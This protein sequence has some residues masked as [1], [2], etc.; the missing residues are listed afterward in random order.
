MKLTLARADAYSVNVTLKPF[1]LSLWAWRGLLDRLVR[2]PRFFKIHAAAICGLVLLGLLP[3]SAFAQSGGVDLKVGSLAVK[4]RYQG[5]PFATNWILGGPFVLQLTQTNNPIFTAT[6]TNDVVFT[7]ILQGTYQAHINYGLKGDV[8]PPINVTIDPAQTQNLTTEL[9]GVLA[10]VTLKLVENGGLLASSHN[11]ELR[12][13]YPLLFVQSL[14][15]GRDTMTA[16]VIAGAGTIQVPDTTPARVFNYQVA[17]GQTKDL[18]TLDLGTGIVELNLLFRGASLTGFNLPADQVFSGK[19]TPVGGGGTVFLGF[20]RGRRTLLNALP[21]D[22]H[23][24]VDFLNSSGTIAPDFAG[25]IPVTVVAGPDPVRVDFEVGGVFGMASGV[26]TENGSGLLDPVR[27][28]IGANGSAISVSD[29]PAADE[30]GPTHVDAL[31][32]PGNV[33]LQLNRNLTTLLVTNLP[34]IQ[35]S[36]KDWGSV[37]LHTGDLLVKPTYNGKALGSTGVTWPYAAGLF[38]NSNLVFQAELGTNGFSFESAPVG[39]YQLQFFNTFV[40]SVQPVGSAIPVAIAQG[41]TNSTV[42][43][44]ASG[45][46]LVSGRLTEN[47]APPSKLHVVTFL[48][49]GG[50]VLRTNMTP[51]QADFRIFLPTGSDALAVEKVQLPFDI[52]AGKETALGAIDVAQPSGPP[53]TLQVTLVYSNRPPSEIGVVGD[54]E[55]EAIDSLGVS[56]GVTRPDALWHASM[57]LPAG[58]YG[59]QVRYAGQVVLPASANSYRVNSGITAGY[60]LNLC[61]GLGLVI[62]TVTINGNPPAQN[63]PITLSPV[64]FTNQIVTAVGPAQPRGNRFAVLMP[65]GNGKGTITGVIGN[66][67]FTFTVPGCG[68]V[69]VGNPLVN[70]SPTVQLVSPTN[71]FSMKAKDTVTLVANASDPDGK[72]VQVDFYADGV[73]IGSSTTVPFRF[74]WVQVPEGTHTI[75]ARAID[76]QTAFTESAPIQIVAVPRSGVHSISV[77]L[78]YPT[79]GITVS[80]PYSG[81]IQAEAFTDTGTITNVEFFQNG[82]SIGKAGPPFFFLPLILSPGEYQ[83]KAVAYDDGGQSAQSSLVTLHVTA[84][85][86]SICDGLLAWWPGEGSAADLIGGHHGALKGEAHYAAGKT[87]FGFELDRNGVS[88]SIEVPA[89]DAW[90]R[91]TNDFSVELWANFR[92]LENSAPGQAGS[93]AFIGADEG[94]GSRNKWFFGLGGG[95][96]Y[97][98]VN[99]AGGAP[100]FLAQTPFGGA[101][102]QWHHLAVTRASGV[103]RIYVNGA[104]AGSETN[105]VEI[106]RVSAPLTIG[107]VEGFGLFGSMDEIAMFNRALT[108]GEVGSIYQAGA[109]GKCL[110]TNPPVQISASDTAVTGSGSAPAAAVFRLT[111]GAS[112]SGP[113]SFTY[114]TVNGTALAGR[115]FTATTGTVVFAPGEAEKSVSIPV[116]ALSKYGP[117]RSFSLRLSGASNAILLRDTFTATILNPLTNQPPTVAITTPPNGLV[118]PT[119]FDGTLAATA[120]DADGAVSKVEFFASGSSLGSVA[121]APYTLRASFPPGSYSLMARATDG[122]GASTISAPVNLIVNALPTAEMVQPTNGTVVQGPYIGLLRA[123]VRDTDGAVVK[124]EYF[125]N[126]NLVG[127]STSSPFGVSVNLPPGRYDLAAQATDDRGFTGLKSKAV[128]LIANA[129]PVVS[130]QSPT[131][132]LTAISP[133]TL[134]L[135]VNASDSDG[136]IAKVEFIVDGAKAGEASTPPYQLPLTLTTGAHS[137]SAR[138]TDNLGATVVAAPVL[139]SVQEVAKPPLAVTIIAPR[140]LASYPPFSDIRIAATVANATN[141][142]TRVDFLAGSTVIG[143]ATTAPFETTWTLVPVGTYQLHA[144]VVD[145]RGNT[146]LSPGVNIAVTAFAGDVAILRPNTNVVVEYASSYLF[147][148]GLS[149]DVI[150]ADTATFETL[151]RH[152]LVIW[153]GSGSRTNGVSSQSVALLKSVVAAGTSVFFLGDNV[154]AGASGLSAAER[155]DWAALTRIKA[156]NGTVAAGTVLLP[157]LGDQNPVVYGNFGQVDDFAL[158]TAPEFV[159]STV[160]TDSVLGRLGTADLLVTSPAL[161]AFDTG[162]ARIFTQAF[163]LVSGTNESSLLARRTL[164]QNAVCWLMRCAGCR[165]FALGIDAAGDRESVGIGELLTYDIVLRHV[166]E[167]EATGARVTDTLPAGATFVEATS[168]AGTWQYANGRVVFEVGHL[169]N[170][171]SNHFTVSVRL[172]N[173]GQATNLVRIE[174]NLLEQTEG[175]TT[176][177]TLTHVTGSQPPV[178]RFLGLENLQPRLELAGGAGVTYVVEYS[179]DLRTWL[180]VTNLTLTTSPASFIDGKAAGAARRFYRARLP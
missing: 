44:L 133:F 171:S 160:P 107:Q 14:G 146:A 54:I 83:F 6:L 72:V 56:A 172:G 46:G 153:Q 93:T 23:L 2:S 49:N 57:F 82:A 80:A 136:S 128:S 64:G 27:L 116:A 42:P 53:G 137:L 94:A 135:L 47:T 31:L 180:A 168:T 162:E 175:L 154:V 55:L 178:L 99:Q 115:D 11:T 69:D 142:I 113:A 63:L 174:A 65:A 176:A 145:A 8:V 20:F 9:N 86:F 28:N 3:F 139:V 152:N 114:A 24:H 7:N 131:N 77:R 67:A 4:L 88:G 165:T 108:A 34:I 179:P 173:S 74:D 71:N 103:F 120:N 159:V 129:P 161:D 170:G 92:Q 84:A 75:K 150:E 48:L 78:V 149:A 140:D 51:P 70:I 33:T 45:F 40:G 100:L 97:F 91:G 98:H 36:I 37:S 138:A 141:A 41:I 169:S 101:S 122:D 125:A 96:L 106:P 15:P 144:R 119:V 164:F 62:G 105:A 66:N 121:N 38:L 12:D 167:C 109:A 104:L 130:I 112:G 118:V 151:R 22:Y 25:G 166:G 95:K 117:S 35:G 177:T 132:G 68:V 29:I 59:V 90:N 60:Q 148:M 52:V 102:N 76:D 21:G 157:H 17:A 50:S 143:S 43:E 127:T 147:A 111:L 32:L 124:V 39:N 87:G 18:G 156:T 13:A 61:G 79:D 30:A 134:I 155:A 5:Q 158:P 81:L 85:C 10:V 163:P 123:D 126:G 73:L 1:S 26:L 58:V 89:S 110:C 16:L 19:L